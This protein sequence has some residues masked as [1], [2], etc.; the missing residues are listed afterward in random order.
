MRK[1]YVNIRDVVASAPALLP[2]FRSDAQARIL[3]WLLLNPDREQ[4]IASLV[5][6]AGVAQPNVL[7]EVNRLVLAGLLRERRAGHTRL[8]SA[9]TDSPYFAG[10]VQLLGHAYGPAQLVPELLDSVSGIEQILIVGSWARRFDGEA[11]PPPA[12]VDVVVVG[13]PDRR[14]LRQANADLEARLDVPVQ[15]TVIS[16][17]DWLSAPSGFIREVQ[18]QPRLVVLDRPP[19]P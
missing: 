8:V 7:R 18:H 2:I 1:A 3:A 19:S 4:P 13:R 16:P 6:V 12:D 11:G 5:P 9:N 15:I 14:A 10:L 17:D